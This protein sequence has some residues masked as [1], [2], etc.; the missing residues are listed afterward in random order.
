MLYVF[1]SFLRVEMSRMILQIGPVVTEE[2]VPTLRS[3]IVCIPAR[4]HLFAIMY[5]FGPLNVCTWIKLPSAIDYLHD[6]MGVGGPPRVHCKCQCSREAGV[7]G[8]DALLH[9][10]SVCGIRSELDKL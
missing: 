4:F 5:N 10:L 2:F 1:D 8:E 6:S 9:R 3:P 7:C